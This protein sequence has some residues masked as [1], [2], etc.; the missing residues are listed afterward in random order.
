M[1]VVIIVFEIILWAPIYTV[2]SFIIEFLKQPIRFPGEALRKSP[3]P[4]VAAGAVRGGQR[5]CSWSGWKLRGALQGWVCCG[6]RR[7]RPSGPRG[8]GH[9]FRA[10][11]W[12]ARL[13]LR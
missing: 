9:A 3:S 13:F 4:T 11:L 5:L 8:K 1:T 12:V 2:I 6:Y 10:A 7:L